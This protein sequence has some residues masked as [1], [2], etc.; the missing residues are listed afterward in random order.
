LSFLQE[1]NPL[2]T[3]PKRNKMRKL[4]IDKAVEV[5]S[6]NAHPFLSLS[7]PK[8]AISFVLPVPALPQ[9]SY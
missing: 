7:P 8:T 5:R 1:I 4:I 6:G 3:F 2:Y 9:V